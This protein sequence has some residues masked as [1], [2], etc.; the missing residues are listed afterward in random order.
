MLS[1]REH[2]WI[3]SETHCRA[4]WSMASAGYLPPLADRHTQPCEAIGHMT[5][6][7]DSETRNEFGPRLSKTKPPVEDKAKEEGQKYG[8]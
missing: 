2:H 3:T 4:A 5:P 6:K 8:P 1:D 7:T